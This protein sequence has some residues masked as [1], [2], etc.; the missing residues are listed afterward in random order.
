M[1]T[2]Q[3]DRRPFS[4]I[5]YSNSQ[6]QG[7]KPELKS[8]LSTSLDLSS[9]TKFHEMAPSTLCLLGSQNMIF[10]LLT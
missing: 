2:S 10:K 3:C 5:Y 8:E 7:L 6:Q 9:L 1:K 4:D